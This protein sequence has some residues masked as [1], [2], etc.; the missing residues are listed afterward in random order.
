M[1]ALGFFGACGDG[2]EGNADQC[3]YREYLHVS[4]GGDVGQKRRVLRA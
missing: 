4:G 1:D 2:G 3:V